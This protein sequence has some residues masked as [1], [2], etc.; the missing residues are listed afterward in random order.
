V[1]AAL[2]D[3][4]PAAPVVRGDVGAHGRRRVRGQEPVALRRVVE[5]TDRDR[6]VA[7]LRGRAAATAAATSATATTTTA[8][9]GRRAATSWIAA[10]RVGRRGLRR[11]SVASTGERGGD[12]QGE[13]GSVH[14]QRFGMAPQR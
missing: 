11:G 5:A 6:R 12:C 2:G 14:A 7:R 9:A 10:A 8:T 1:A 4:G 13:K 3:P